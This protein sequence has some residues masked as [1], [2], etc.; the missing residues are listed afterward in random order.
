M[1]KLLDLANAFRSDKGTTK[2][3][4]TNFAT[5]YEHFFGHLHDKEMRMLEIGLDN[6]GP[7]HGGSRFDRVIQQTPSINMWHTYFEK[8]DI[9]GFDINNVSSEVLVNLPRFT[10]FK[11]DQGNENSYKFL[12]QQMQSHFKQESVEG[13][14]DIIIDDA[15][16]AWYHQ[17]MSFSHLSKLVKPGGFYVIEDIQW[18]PNYDRGG[19]KAGGGA[20]FDV[21]NL[22]QCVNSRKL[23]DTLFLNPEEGAEIPTYL[24][25]ATEKQRESHSGLKYG[26]ELLRERR[27]EYCDI[28]LNEAKKYDR[29]LLI[30]KVIDWKK[31]GTVWKGDRWERAPKTANIV[32]LRKKDY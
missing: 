28:L 7:E 5:L 12:E 15:S 8:G 22:P 6:G 3:S 31:Y 25:P 29:M 10:F 4:A 24:G 11:G 17:Q 2:G 1:P 27:P 21:N 9:W 23:F 18:Q 32:I 19:G 13:T 26:I 20:V 16:H 30:D 14:F